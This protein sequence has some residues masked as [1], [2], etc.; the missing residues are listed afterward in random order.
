[1]S[2]K[3]F[4]KIFLS[5][6]CTVA[7]VSIMSHSV[8]AEEIGNI[9]VLG[10]SIS[11]GYGL[12]EQERNYGSWLGEYF[13][14]NVDNFAV[15]GKTTQQL[16]DSLESDSNISKSLKNSDLI[17]IS[18]GGNDVMDV[19]YDELVNIAQGV[20]SPQSSQFNVSP[21][22]IQS[23]IFSFSSTLAPAA[24]LAGENIVKITDMIS[25]I[26]PNAKLMFQTVYNPFETNDESM[27]PMYTPMYVVTSIY[28]SAINN[29]VKNK[30][31]NEFA[32]IQKKFK[33]NCPLFTNIEEMDIHPNSIGHFLIAEEIV[34]KLKIPGE[35]AIFETGLDD[36]PVQKI[37]DI[38]DEII[39]EIN[40]LAQGEFRAEEIENT[41]IESENTTQDL[42]ETILET[43][44]TVSP[45]TEKSDDKSEKNFKD[46]V[47]IILMLAA[48]L[49]L[50]VSIKSTFTDRKK[51]R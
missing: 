22:A 48:A 49:S 11:A 43:E 23:L 9:T 4:Q 42:T 29:A 5:S 1:M 15:D 25:E 31:D 34:Q 2:F 20:S 36:F 51:I 21:E 17:C 46:K 13:D 45:V 32:D 12:E 3:V 28:L 47:N 19:F 18:I 16:M 6:V 38:P 7:A 33:G 8:S 10:D 14:A 24:M 41:F 35:N 37:N 27:E 44:K 26:N 39:G 30:D 40:L 50:A